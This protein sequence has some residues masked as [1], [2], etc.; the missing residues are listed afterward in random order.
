MR[1]FSRK[2][3]ETWPF[4]IAC[5]LHVALLVALRPP[6]AP[7]VSAPKGSEPLV[8][9][10]LEPEPAGP[11][12]PTSATRS[13]PRRANGASGRGAR[14][15]GSGVVAAIAAAGERGASSPSRVPSLVAPIGPEPAARPSEGWA[16]NPTGKVDLGLGDTR[17]ALVRQMAANGQLGGEG[18]A[19]PGHL[20][21]ALDALDVERGFGRGGPVVQA[22]EDAARDPGAPPEGVAI[23]D[24]TIERSGAISVRVS[25]ETANR[26]DWE[27]LTTYVA[28][29]VKKR[30]VR[31]PDGAQG[32]RVGVR[33]EAK[34]RYPDGRDPKKS[35]AFASSTGLTTHETKD[36]VD[37][38]L[39]S[40][41]VGV[42]GKVCSG[43]L[44]LSAAGPSLSGG[45]SPENVGTHPERVVAGRQTYEARM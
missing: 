13:A 42:R 23:F 38:V 14:S 3:R 8:E 26:E 5:T 40:V 33:V 24:I 16:F 4:V 29:A 19:S 22:V 25:E 21:E 18:E 17:G 45:C 31:I 20:V 2:R 27:R 1:D 36:H 32:L 43:G 35:G 28:S 41:T 15:Q 39:P 12:A 44:T 11:S 9:L 37:I 10:V 30:A 7:S 34:I 6:P